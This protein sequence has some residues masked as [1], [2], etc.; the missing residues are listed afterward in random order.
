MIERIYLYIIE[1]ITALVI[2]KSE[3]EFDDQ[4]FFSS[5]FIFDLNSVIYLKVIYLTVFLTKLLFLFETPPKK[6]RRVFTK[7]I[8]VWRRSK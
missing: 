1:K 4:L 8:L 6:N 5:F 7:F 2:P 3:N